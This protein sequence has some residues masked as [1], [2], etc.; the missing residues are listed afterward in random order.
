MNPHTILVPG[1][2]TEERVKLLISLTNI[3]SDK[4]IDALIDHLSRGHATAQAAALNQV[5]LPNFCR[6]KASLIIAN[7]IVEKIK[8]IDWPELS[9]NR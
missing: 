8:E 6:A 3:R 4:V 2:E 1:A 7:G 9:E 5:E